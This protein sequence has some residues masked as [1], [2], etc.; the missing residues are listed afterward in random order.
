MT[1]LPIRI[2]NMPD[3][4]G[5]LG[6]VDLHAYNTF[7][8]ENWTLDSLFGH[9]TSEMGRRTMLLWGTGSEGSW[10]IDVSASSVEPQFPIARQ[11]TGPITVTKGELIVV[12]YEILTMAAQF[13]N[14]RIDREKDWYGTGIDLPNG[15]YVCTISQL[16]EPEL[17][18]THDGPDF[19]LQLTPG[20]TPNWTSTAWF[21]L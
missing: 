5:F 6:I 20:E 12:N 16:T 7:V 8:S 15:D 4:S 3:D 19:H 14:E 10:R 1:P 2:E 11:A 21:D 13:E 18:R 9:F 17:S